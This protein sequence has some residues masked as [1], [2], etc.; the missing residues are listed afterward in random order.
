MP[1]DEA[2]SIIEARLGSQFDVDHGQRFIDMGRDGVLNHIASHS[3]DGIPLLDCP[4]CGPILVVRGDQR[5]GTRIYCAKCTGEFVV[6]AD[7]DGAWQAIPSGRHGS[8]RDLEPEPDNALITKIVK[9]ASAAIS[10]TA[11]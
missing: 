2:L 11:P 9:E 4:W 10:P 1:I 5:P 7:A 6:E 8:P 3:D